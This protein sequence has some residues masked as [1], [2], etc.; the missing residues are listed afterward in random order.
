MFTF[1]LLTHGDAQGPF[2][3]GR[4]VDLAILARWPDAERRLLRQCGPDAY[5]HEVLA[6]GAV[7]A[8]VFYARKNDRG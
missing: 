4:D 2:D 8:W 5:V 3:E 1:W 7:V 6:S